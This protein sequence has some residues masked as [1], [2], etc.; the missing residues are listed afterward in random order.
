MSRIGIIYP[1]ANIDTVP[2]LI[3]AAETFADHGYDVDLF[4]LTLAGQPAPEFSSPRI[5][6]RS[7]GHE[8][9]ADHSTAGLR[10]L[11]KRAGWLPNSARAPLARG[12]A[13]LGAGLAHGTRFAARARGVVAET[14]A[15]PFACVI[16]VDP[17]GL[18][19]AQTIAHGAPVGYYSLE[20]LLSY[21]VGSPAEHRLKAQERTLSRQA[22]FIVVQDEARGRLLA[23][24]NG[25]SW[26]RLV[27]VPNAP[28]GPARRRP[29]SYWHT[30]FE[31]PADARVVVHSGSLGDWTGIQAIVDS[32]ADW[33]AQWVLV[34]HTRYDGHSSAYVD[35][36]RRRADAGRVWFSLSPVPR[37]D[38][39]PLIDGAHVGLAFYVSSGGS[40]FTQRNIQTIG[41]S[42]GKLAYY[43]R[44]GL[45]VI[46]NRAASI[47][48]L[49]RSSGC[50]VAVEDAAAIGPALDRISGGYADFSA[51]ACAF[52]EERLDFRRAFG[53]VVQRVDALHRARRD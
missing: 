8:G 5:W 42:S 4:T 50:G 34:I 48:E 12:Y 15:E 47:A 17:D 32:A 18:A 25:V 31:L 13:V 45:P 7:L 33:P 22:E 28:P 39:D 27:L 3:G 53:E 46:V 9:L 51:R 49:I 26:E 30:R 37:Q 1:R 29:S 52:F 23:E 20:L 38:Y 6:L 36:L 21:E 11:V 14:S 44:A 16:G 35:D 41:L 40:S 24:D 19:L 43:L 10:S 2:S